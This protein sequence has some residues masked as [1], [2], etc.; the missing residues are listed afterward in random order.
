MHSGILYKELSSSR[1][2]FF[3][4][5]D[6]Y[7]CIPDVVSNASRMYSECISTKVLMSTCLQKKSLWR[8][9]WVLM[10]CLDMKCHVTRHLCLE[11]AQGTLVPRFSTSLMYIPQMICQIAVI[12]QYLFTNRTRFGRCIMFSHFMNCHVTRHLGLIGTQ[13][14]LVPRF[15]CSFM[16]I[17]LMIWQYSVTLECIATSWTCEIL[18][19]CDQMFSQCRMI[20]EEFPTA[21][22]HKRQLIRI[23]VFLPMVLAIFIIFITVATHVTD[24]M[25]NFFLMMNC[26][27]DRKV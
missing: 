23:M 17:P 4:V 20:K 13:G 9:R 26:W 11:G 6:H 1:S 15:I 14:T 24:R 2:Y 8:S 21:W 7:Q 18:C 25:K 10:S 3:K 27:F 16:Y 22:T 12:L 5:S 19:V